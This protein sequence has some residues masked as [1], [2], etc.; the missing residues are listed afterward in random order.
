[1]RKN[2]GVIEA[3]T[4]ST[5]TMGDHRWNVVVELLLVLTLLSACQRAIYPHEFI[6]PQTYVVLTDDLR[7]I[8]EACHNIVTPGIIIGCYVPKTRTVYARPDDPMTVLHE[9]LHAG[10]FTHGQMD[11]L[12]SGQIR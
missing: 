4:I 1:M 3:E 2:V 6:I 11:E 8:Q 12:L 7:I 5:T 10:G 9:I